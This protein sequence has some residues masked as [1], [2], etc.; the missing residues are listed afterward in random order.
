MQLNQSNRALVSILCVAAIALTAGLIHGCSNHGPS[1]H[2]RV[3]MGATTAPDAIA[4]ARRWEPVVLLGAQIPAAGQLAPS[5][6]VAFRW[7][8]GW[9]PVPVQVDERVRRSWSQI[10]PEVC[11]HCT[12]EEL[13]YA[14]VTTRVGPDCPW[15][16]PCNPTIDDDD[17]IVFMARD[18]GR[19][20]NGQDLP[21]G[22]G[23]HYVEVRVDD[24]TGD[25]TGYV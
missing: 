24:P 5:E 13:F 2:E 8:Q 12:I 17:E 11:A 15:N 1:E 21:A 14:D 9:Q 16:Q 19:P 10:H 7:R 23:T 22:V 3:S 6:L 20:F 18:V 25:R 4:P